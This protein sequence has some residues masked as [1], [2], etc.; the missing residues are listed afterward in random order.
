MSQKE[1]LKA[2]GTEFSHTLYHNDLSGL[3]LGSLPFFEADKPGSNAAYGGI[4]APLRHPSWN[5]QNYFRVIER[6]LGKYIE[7]PGSSPECENRIIVAGEATW[8]DYRLRAVVTP[9]SFDEG[10]PLGGFCGIVARFSDAN[11]Y[12]A[13]VIDRN[14]QVKLLQRRDGNIT[15]LE[16]RPLEFCLGQ[17][18]TLTL[19]LKG[20]KIQG[21]A[22]PYTGATN[23]FGT[24][25]E[26]LAGKVGYISDVAARFGPFSVEA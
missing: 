25:K 26:L 10:S 21:T 5:A 20:E 24:S 3:P 13:L 1:E 4:H 9:I 22:G 15:T 14:G 16:A 7:A 11:N 6:G 17:S 8:K 23:V 12:I 18:L 19:I 2:S